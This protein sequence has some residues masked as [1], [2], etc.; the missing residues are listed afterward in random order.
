MEKMSQIPKKNE[1]FFIMVIRFIGYNCPICNCSLT[2][3]GCTSSD[4]SFYIL[5][6]N[7]YNFYSYSVLN[8]SWTLNIYGDKIKNISKI[9]IRNPIINI[10]NKGECQNLT[11]T[12][13]E[14]SQ[15]KK[16]ITRLDNIK[17]F[18]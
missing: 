14:P 6:D 13:I 17:G 11:F 15:L 16:M 8:G 12:Y 2:N 10:E 4:H 5:S 7:S 1:S 9:V 18:L 3:M